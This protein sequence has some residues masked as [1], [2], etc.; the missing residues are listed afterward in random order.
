MC[1][2]DLVLSGFLKQLYKYYI[3]HLE[4]CGSCHKRKKSHGNESEYNILLYCSPSIM[5]L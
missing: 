2:A 1:I 4:G 5:V 3:K